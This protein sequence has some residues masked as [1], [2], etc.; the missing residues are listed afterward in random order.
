MPPSGRA[1][2]QIIQRAA[3]ARNINPRQHMVGWDGWTAN[4]RADLAFR[5]LPITAGPV[6]RG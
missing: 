3:G 2:I 4:I 5:G 6:N 1:D